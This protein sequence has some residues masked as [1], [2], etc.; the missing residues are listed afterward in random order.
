MLTGSGPTKYTI[1]VAPMVLID[2]LGAKWGL[3]V[4][5]PVSGGGH[6]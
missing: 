6:L 2:G 4:S 1:W 3:A 5:D